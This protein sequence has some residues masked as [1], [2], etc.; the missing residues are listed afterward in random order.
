MN[1]HTDDWIMKKLQNH[2]NYAKEHM[3]QNEIIGVFLHGSQNYGL[4]FETSDVDSVCLVM[5]SK[6]DITSGREPISKELIIPEFNEKI[7]VWE[8]RKFIN[9]LEKGGFNQLEILY[10]NYCILNPTY[11]SFWKFVTNHRPEFVYLNSYR[12]ANSFLGMLHRCVKE[13]KKDNT[14]TNK[15]YMRV[16]FFS[17][18]LARYLTHVNFDS[19]L[20]SPNSDD[21]KRVRLDDTM[22]KEYAITTSQTILE[23][24]KD[25]IN[26]Y[27]FM[28]DK[29]DFKPDRN[30]NTIIDVIRNV[31]FLFIKEV[32]LTK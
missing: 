22:T 21:L 19:I 1:F 5:P 26:K 16:L 23:K 2:Y 15:E 7:V 9:F 10:T 25:L 28:S 6:Y 8:I 30:D 14:N 17:Q 32:V 13:I 18:C 29:Y 27:D 20:N 12:T 24:S 3:I 31:L 4:D 11:K